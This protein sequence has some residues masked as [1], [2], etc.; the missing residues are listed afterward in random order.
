MKNTKMLKKNYEFKNILT[1]G[2]Y[3]S[4]NKIEVFITKNNQKNNKIGLA[5][6]VKRGKAYQRNR[7]KRLLRENYQKIEN[8]IET[9]NS[10]V[11]LCKKSEEITQITYKEIKD[12][13]E[14]IFKKAQI[15]K[16]EEKKWKKY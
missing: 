2:K 16:K 1:K 7:I 12:D 4:G 15:L 11:F 3:Y 13:M 6:G 10:I 5:I 8:K 9:G 14:E